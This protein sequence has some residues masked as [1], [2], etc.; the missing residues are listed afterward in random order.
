MATE[1]S[2]YEKIDDLKIIDSKGN[3]PFVPKGDLKDLISNSWPTVKESLK[4]CSAAEIEKLKDFI[5]TKAMVVF[6]ILVALEKEE[7]IKK[8]HHE[9]FDDKML[10]VGKYKKTIISLNAK[11]SDAAKATSIIA[12]TFKDGWSLQKINAFCDD[13][14]WPF[15]APTFRKGEFQYKFHPKTPMPF[16]NEGDS[17]SSGFSTVTKW[18]IHVNH[19][20]T[21]LVSIEL[22]PS[23]GKR[24]EN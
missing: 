6:A 15:L 23:C 18:S 7:C 12:A 4:Q 13:I 22:L 8:F 1:R 24:Y 17:Q 20:E 3:Q 11:E 5:R 19:L 14:Q 9:G 10:P 16:L 21:D 2:L